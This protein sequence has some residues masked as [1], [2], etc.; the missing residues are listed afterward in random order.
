[1]KRWNSK[2]L[3]L[4][5]V[6]SVCVA[7][8]V[9]RPD[10]IKALNEAKSLHSSDRPH[11]RRG[12]NVMVESVGSWDTQ[13][14]DNN[15]DV[16]IAASNIFGLNVSIKQ[17]DS[18]W[19]DIIDAKNEILGRAI[20]SKNIGDE[21]VG[22][23]G[24]TPVFIGLNTENKIAGVELL[25]N[26][27]S[28]GF[29]NRIERAGFFDLWNGKTLEEAAVFVPDAVSGATITSNAVI[30]NVNKVAQIATSI[31]SNSVFNWL[32]LF[33]FIA[34]LVIVVCGIVICFNPARFMKYRIWLMISSIIVLGIWLGEF[35]SI[36][37]FYTWISGGFVIRYTILLLF[38]VSFVLPLFFNKPIY[39]TY[40]CPFGSLQELLGKLTNRKIQISDNVAFYLGLIRKMYLVLII[41]IALSFSN[42]DF[43]N[44]EPFT[45]F[46][47]QS[48]SVFVIFMASTILLLSL[49]INRPWCRFICPTGLVFN[50]LNKGIKW[51]RK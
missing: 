31:K 45:I 18:L 21:I 49:F 36:Q 46:V 48:V 29:V 47:Y 14:M 38:V 35:M 22:Y 50:I 44:F 33:K 12:D 40:L 6:I 16:S 3:G 15:N 42:V 25:N 4:L 51:K 13:L 9:F 26:A 23:A 24:A 7:V 2:I 5:L 17:T 27:E 32:D 28:V 1:M 30:Q 20:V 19:F 43:T 34:V 11:G 10:H 37:L 39:C 8:H 41:V